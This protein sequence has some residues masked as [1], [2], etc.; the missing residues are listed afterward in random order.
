M[1]GSGN[2]ERGSESE[3]GEEPSCLLSPNQ[4]LN[5]MRKL[6]SISALGRDLEVAIDTGG[7]GSVG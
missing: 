6:T 2:E 1:S 3:G 4:K 5:V 7:C